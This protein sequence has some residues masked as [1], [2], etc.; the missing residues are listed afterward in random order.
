M[1]VVIDCRCGWFTESLD[2][3][4]LLEAELVADRHERKDFKRP[5]RHDTRIE[6]VA[7]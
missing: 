4:D 3:T 5:Y 1:T 6:E 2:V 7:A